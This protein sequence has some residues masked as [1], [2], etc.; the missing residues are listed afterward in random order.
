MESPCPLRGGELGPGPRV[1]SLEVG[2]ESAF[3]LWPLK[4]RPLLRI[5]SWMGFAAVSDL[6]QRK[7][8]P[9]SGCKEGGG[10]SE[11]LILV[12][13]GVP[14]VLLSVQ[15]SPFTCGNEERGDLQTWGSWGT[16]LSVLLFSLCDSISPRTPISFLQTV[17]SPN[18]CFGDCP[19]H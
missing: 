9:F 2:W 14:T 16:W 6:G 8:L 19:D 10:A 17:Y 15:S 5:P 11:G 1:A 4:K 3:F 7:P 18:F 12:A 13:L